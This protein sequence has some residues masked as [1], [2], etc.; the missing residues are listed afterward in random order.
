MV[1]QSANDRNE[2][3]AQL[4]DVDA[5]HQTLVQ[6]VSGM[7]NGVADRLDDL[8]KADAS[9]L[10]K[11]SALESTNDQTV[12]AATA[13]LEKKIHD[14]EHKLDQSSKAEIQSVCQHLEQQ[15]QTNNSN[16]ER[17]LAE[18]DAGNQQL[19]E[20]LLEVEKDVEGKV[21]DNASSVQ[22]QLTNLDADNKNNAQMLVTLR[23]SIN[24]QVQ[25][26]KKVDAERQRSEAKAKEDLDAN[27]AANAR[28]IADLKDQLGETI[29]QRVKPTE[30]R[31][32][33]V[34]GDLK[35]M[36]GTLEQFEDAIDKR[37][38]TDVMLRI[39][40]LEKDNQKAL[41]DLETQIGDSISQRM[42]PSEEKLSKVDGEI[43]G[44]HKT[45]AVFESRHVETT[46]SLKEVTVLTE[47]IQTQVNDQGQK[48]AEQSA[49]DLNR[50]NDRL[51]DMENQAGLSDQKIK[52]LDA[53]NQNLLEKVLGMDGNLSERLDKQEQMDNT[54][55]NRINELHSNN[56]ES[57]SSI[58]LRLGDLDKESK[59]NITQIVNLQETINIQAERVNAVDADRQKAAEKAKADLES[60][61]ASNAKAIADL[62]NELGQ[63]IV[64]K[65]RPAED[66]LANID[67][68]IQGLN[69][70]V[71]VFEQKH[72]ETAEKIQEVTV[73]TSNIQVQVKAQEQKM[74]EQSANDMN[75][76]KA[77]LKDVDAGHQTLVQKVSGMENG[78]ADRLDDLAKADA[79]LLAKLSALESTNDQTVR[80]AT[81]DLEK[82]I[83]DAEHKLD[84]SSKAEIQSVCQH[85][86]QQM[87]TNNSNT[88]R[89]LAEADAG[90][91]QLLEKL[92]EVEKDVE[93]KVR[94]NAS[95]VQNQLT[96]LDADNKNNAQM[97]VT[98]RESINIQVQETKKVDAERQ[99][100]EAKAKED[101]DA[102]AAANARA[103]ADLKD[104]L[105]ETIAQRV[106]PTEDRLSEV[107]GDLKAMHGTLEQF[108]D[109]IDKRINTD[110]MLRIEN[111]EKDNQKALGDL[112]TQIG[113]SIS[114]RMKPSEEK[115][116][117]VDGEI[118]GLHK[119]VA[120]F[121]SRHVETTKSLKE[122]TVLTE[123]IQT[124]VND[125]GQKM[126]EQSANDLN[127]INDRLQDMENQ[128][129]LSDQKIKELD[130]GNQNLLEK[131]LGMDGNLSE[132]LDKQE[133]M[134]N[135]LM[136]RINEL[137]SNNSES[138]S[139]I[140]LRLGDLDKESKDNIT[141]IVNL[142]ETINIQAERVNAVDA[143]RQKAAEKAKADLESTVASNA[144][145]IADLKNELGQ[146]IVD[147]FRPVE[148]RPVNIDDNIQGLNKT[149]LLGLRE[150]VLS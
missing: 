73:L 95:S 62:K 57:V 103:I 10:A 3:K 50:I 8:A 36:H 125:Q 123:R 13:D 117:K 112:E 1:E 110:V 56:S 141:Q 119:T 22:N 99:R 28:A 17:R 94:D 35:A 109:A 144:K 72:T 65:F 47:R 74:V 4:K 15:M 14:A 19:L 18:A 24:I 135:T 5:G 104:Q 93:G 53:G 34:N 41:G 96:N 42:K 139:S 40:N 69:K 118:S 92:L 120:V 134:D 66:R 127:R 63:S 52:E 79:S 83:H 39:E 150:S 131:V 61:V 148:D 84:Q 102:N 6:K 142:Q 97:L 49:N 32:S 20:K 76:I 75:E 33:E 149:F 101:L 26:T 133:Q 89:R 30:D 146:S 48:M 12:R 46:K 145:A 106:K 111:L 9:L 29:A 38:N 44:L 7:E 77:Q 121:E 116:S 64:D 91:Q 16:T 130:A 87:Q 71:A 126:A 37:I 68:D 54:L 147:K 11:L 124:Q 122:V 67:G 138:V 27:A 108:E 43:S 114:Q 60:T 88:E 107:N 70:T 58:Q 86:E 51:Q 81:A 25:E 45:V 100:S 21:R 132:R 137:H 143:D 115:L 113:D 140:Q 80:A 128:A 105:G 2:I 98:L 136:N 31:L 78:V 90:N 129:G 85:L 55:M 82:K 59:D 23:E